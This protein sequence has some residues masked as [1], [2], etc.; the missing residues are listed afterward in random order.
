MHRTIAPQLAQYA[1]RYLVVITGGKY[2]E[3]GLDPATLEM[4]VRTPD[5]ELRPASQLLHGTI[6][7]IY[8]LLRVAVADQITLANETC[9]LILDEVSVHSDP[10]RTRRMLDTLKAIS[11]ETQVIEVLDWVREDLTSSRDRLI[12]LNA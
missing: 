2:S 3:V 12:Q 7:Q 4:T 10:E 8:L 11:E 5:G 9:P 1:E 6:E